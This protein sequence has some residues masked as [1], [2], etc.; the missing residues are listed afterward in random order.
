MDYTPTQSDL[1]LISTST[2]R[3]M[4]LKRFNFRFT[5][6]LESISFGFDGGRNQPP[7]NFY[8]SPPC[9]EERYIANE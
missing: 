2:L 8:D 5:Y 6:Y 1:I 7:L 4:T 3:Q 9:E